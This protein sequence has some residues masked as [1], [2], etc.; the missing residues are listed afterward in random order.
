MLKRGIG[1]GMLCLAGHAYSAE[2]TVTITDDITKD[3]SECSLR[4]AIE[5]VNKGMPEAGYMGCG[6]KNALS[7]I[8]LDKQKTYTLNAKVDVKAS[9]ALKTYY[10]TT[11]TEEA[12][13]GL[14][15]A[16]IKMAGKDQ[17]F[18]IDHDP[19][20][21]ALITIKEVSFEGC[22][23]SIC[24]DKGGIFYNN[25]R[26]V[27][28]Y[29]KLS[30]GN[31]RL[32]GAIYN[33][34][35]S[36]A[37]QN[38]ISQVAISDSILENNTAVTGAVLYGQR[39]AFALSSVVFKNNNTTSDAANIFSEKPIA[40]VTLLN[41]K[42]I[43]KL[44]NSTFLNNS[45][46]IINIR[47]GIAV[48][49]VTIV[50]N[51]AG[52]QF[53]SQEGYGYLANS[54]VVGNGSGTNCQFNADDKTLIQNNL[55]GNECK[56]GD[57]K[58][59][60]EFWGGSKLFAGNS[61]EGSCKSL[62]EDPDA[63]LCP[64]STPKNTFLGYIR[65][66]ILFSAQNMFDTLILNKGRLDLSLDSTQL[67]CETM[68][69]R[70]KNRTTD[71]SWCDRGAIEIV[72]PSSKQR[73]G[74]DLKVGEVAKLNILEYLGDSD[75]YPKE[76]CE[77]LLNMKNPAGGEWQDGCA[78]IDQ[79]LTKS[80]GTLTLDIDG[81]LVY[82]PN[83]NWHGADIFNLQIVTSSTHFNENKKYIVL[84]AYMVQEPNNEF[85]DK[86]VKTSGGAFGFFSLFAVLGLVGIRR[87]KK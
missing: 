54:I 71:N 32:G 36:S 51:Q 6:G 11:V 2:I 61:S 45:G 42:N 83:G 59:P 86:S 24:A 52:V 64:Y 63:L 50:G 75:L 55:V 49:N 78:Y 66:R 12:I 70:N 35:E 67:M 39:P 81:N 4:E 87:F 68:D 65:P 16:V 80:K 85:E 28:Q 5:Y 18:N 79:T 53:D 34:G 48:N 33:V 57:A 72:V 10:D 37:T 77:S 21:L 30:G 38:Y 44:S 47:D 46:Y 82:T 60:N 27:L 58:Y 76:K 1:I 20:D 8:L 9:L 69:Q 17:I 19:K 14:N 62:I 13:A 22:N 3:D 7:T 31:A 43:N 41:D 40:D 25:E 26:L 29:V 15:N 56:S 23:K 73:I 84:E 74:Q